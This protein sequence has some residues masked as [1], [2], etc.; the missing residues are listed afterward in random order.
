MILKTIKYEEFAGTPKAWYLENFDLQKINLI[1]GRNASGKTRTLNLIRTLA[2]LVSG[3]RT[4][5]PEA[6]FEAVFDDEGTEVEYTTRLNHGKVISEQLKINKKI[7]LD[8]NQSG[9]GL[10]Y[11]EELK[12]DI[13]FQ[14]SENELACVKKRD[15][16]Q[17]PFLEAFYN[18]GK[19]LRHYQF[20]YDL[21][22]NI[23][24]IL[25]KENEEKKEIDPKQAD[26][27][28]AI[29]KEAEK[30]YGKEFC[31]QVIKEMKMIGYNISEI[32]VTQLDEF[33]IKSSEPISQ[34]E[35]LFVVEKGI[36]KKINQIELSQGMFRALSLIIQL[37]YSTLKNTENIIL[38]DDIGEGLDYERA[39]E[40][41]KILIDKAQKSNIQLIMSTN[42]RFVMNNVPL[43]YWAILYRKENKCKM[44]NYSNSKEK[45]D[46]FK[47]TGLS[48]FDFFSTE[49]YLNDLDDSDK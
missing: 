47:Y 36:D 16:I 23:L 9:K 41:I 35:G 20:G 48:N 43:E 27:V 42:D 28:V 30:I 29:F 13:N 33:L 3:D 38:I 25:R 45:F 6:Y 44:L 31:D 24:V 26:Q 5:I 40:L 1:V 49:F 18:W 22:K 34:P 19:S 21:G 46:E 11:A 37:N 10:I 15:A 32:G 4:M 12:K 7:L 2:D 14:L 39:T 17:H 8:R